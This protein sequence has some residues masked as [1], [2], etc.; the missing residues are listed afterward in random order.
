MDDQYWKNIYKELS[1]IFP[2]E[3]FPIKENIKDPLK[4]SEKIN[5]NDI[6]LLDN[7]FPWEWREEPLWAHL[8]EKLLERKVNCKIICI[9]D[10]WKRLLEQYDEW[11]QAYND[12]LI[13]WFA[14]DK[15]ANT[16]KKYLTLN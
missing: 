12:W 13:L 9:S 15:N 4:Y 7:Y 8:L 2:D 6:V 5:D 10:Y 1:K 16:V 14:P 11:E 3:D